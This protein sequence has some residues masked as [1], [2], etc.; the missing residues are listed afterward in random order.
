MKVVYGLK[1]VN[2]PQF[3]FLCFLGPSILVPSSVSKTISCLLPQ[4]ISDVLI[5][6][7]LKRKLVYE[8]RV[9]Q[10]KQF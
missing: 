5:P 1:W 2:E 10:F 4:S 7:A 6:V 3:T 9:C 8:G